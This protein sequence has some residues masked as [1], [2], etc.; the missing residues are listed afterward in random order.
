MGAGYDSPAGYIEVIARPTVDEYLAECHDVRKAFLAAI[1]ISHYLDCEA[2]TSN[3]KVEEVRKAVSDESPAI[4]DIVAIANLA[5]HYRISRPNSP[6]RNRSVV[7][8]FVPGDVVSHSDGSFFSDGA[9]YAQP[10]IYIRADN[11]YASLDETLREALSYISI[12]AEKHKVP[13]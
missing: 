10:V 11:T 5:K 7:E 4:T 13:N 3:V 6:D 1:A 9:G 2:Q 12:R 8:A